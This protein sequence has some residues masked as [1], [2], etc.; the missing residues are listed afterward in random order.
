[1]MGEVGPGLRVAHVSEEEECLT[2]VSESKRPVLLCSVGEQ[3][4]SM[5]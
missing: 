3:G 4:G 2:L 5:E 1:M